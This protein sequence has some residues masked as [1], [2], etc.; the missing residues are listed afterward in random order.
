MRLTEEKEKGWWDIDALGN[1][2]AAF[3]ARN[4]T[5]EGENL[6]LY[7]KNVCMCSDVQRIA[8]R[9]IWNVSGNGKKRRGVGIGKGGS[10]R[11]MESEW[12]LHQNCSIFSL[13]ERG[14]WMRFCFYFFKN[15]WSLQ[16]SGYSRIQVFLKNTTQTSIQSKKDNI[17]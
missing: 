4:S 14:W 17:Q 11:G 7:L 6:L 10:N 12:T 9:E 5:W 16:E 8:D 15:N 13:S 2:Y 3:S 1:S